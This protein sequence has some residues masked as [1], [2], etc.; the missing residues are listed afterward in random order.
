MSVPADD[1][2]RP[3]VSITQ[4]K[5]NEKIINIIDNSSG[6]NRRFNRVRSQPRA[7]ETAGAELDRGSVAEPISGSKRLADRL[8]K[9]WRLSKGFAEARCLTCQERHTGNVSRAGRP[10]NQPLGKGQVRERPA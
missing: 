3:R 6:S 1:S 4:E 7:A 8:S 9:T 2:T 10:T 5:N